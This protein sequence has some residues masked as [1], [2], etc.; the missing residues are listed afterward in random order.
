MQ[1]DKFNDQ[2]LKRY[3]TYLD[4]KYPAPRPS[5]EYLYR[6]IDAHY[7]KVPFES[8]SLHIPPGQDGEIPYQANLGSIHCNS[9]ALCS[10]ICSGR[11]GYCFE[12]NGAFAKLLDALGFETNHT[13]ARVSKNP[14]QDPEKVGW[15]WEPISHR[16]TLVY[17]DGEIYHCD[18]GF[19]TG[20]P[21][22]PL[23]LSRRVTT[24]DA[25]EY[26]LVHEPLPPNGDDKEALGYT[27]YHYF[28]HGSTGGPLYHV[29]RARFH[30]QDF[31]TLNFFHAH[32]PCSGFAKM[33]VA[34]LPKRNGD[35]WNVV[36]NSTETNFEIRDAKGR[37][38]EKRKLT[39]MAE[40]RKVLGEM[41]ITL[42]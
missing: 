1:S 35:R 13:I 7:Y 37:S 32:N 18:V 11:G 24:T 33:M 3:L 40:L 21:N 22:V 26:H 15:G 19:G 9:E 34:T 20:Q 8:L 23:P 42:P 17:L 31:D 28:K 6:L 2:Q 16:I 4:L 29:Y 36:G 10:K 38:K 39:N 41:N 25:G 30:P 12:L 5:Y 14:N 27:V